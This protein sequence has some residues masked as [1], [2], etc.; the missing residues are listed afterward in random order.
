MPQ[1]FAPAPVVQVFKTTGARESLIGAGLQN[2]WR[3][4]L[5]RAR[6]M[7]QPPYILSSAISHADLS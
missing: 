2:N 4:S 1:C 5:I 7:R 6:W 3:E